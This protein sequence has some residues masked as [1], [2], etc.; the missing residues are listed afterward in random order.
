M[1]STGILRSLG[2]HVLP[3]RFQIDPADWHS[4]A[5]TQQH[6]GAAKAGCPQ[7]GDPALADK[8]GAV[9]PAI[10]ASLQRETGLEDR[11]VFLEVFYP[12]ERDDASVLDAVRRSIRT[13][14]PVFD[15]A[16]ARRERY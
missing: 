5:G 8:P 1:E 14:T 16:Q 13:L 15:S 3:Q 12:F 4:L 2:A 11:P 10:A 6:L 9:D 7:F